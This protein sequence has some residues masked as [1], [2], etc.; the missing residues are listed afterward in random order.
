MTDRTIPHH[1]IRQKETSQLHTL[2]F[3]NV[4]ISDEVP[5]NQIHIKRPL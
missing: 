5:I 4:M 2:S 1:K 3:T